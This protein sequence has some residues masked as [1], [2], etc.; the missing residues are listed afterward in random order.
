MC[1]A[2]DSP[3]WHLPEGAKMR[4]GKGKIRDIKYSPD[5]TTMA[6]AI[7][8]GVWLYDTQTSRELNFFPTGASSARSIAY[9]PDGTIL[10]MG[11]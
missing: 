10:A 4:L 9:S 11:C 8:I 6:V 5:G 3:Q 7:N 1:Y 2:Q